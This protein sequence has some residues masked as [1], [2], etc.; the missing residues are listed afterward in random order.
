MKA[1]ECLTLVN[2]GED[3]TLGNGDVSEKLVQLL[4]VADGKLEMAGNDT[5]LLVV[6]GGVAG[7]FENLSREVLEDCGKV[8]GSTWKQNVRSVLNWKCESRMSL[9]YQHRHAERSCPCGGVCEHD[10]QGRRDQPWRNG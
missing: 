1:E 3:T 10:R 7:K 2:I 8:D 4:I 6:T 5:R 9:T